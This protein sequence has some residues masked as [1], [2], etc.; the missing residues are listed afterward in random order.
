MTSAPAAG[1]SRWSDRP[2]V[3]SVRLFAGLVLYGT[4]LAVLVKAHLGLDPWTVFSQGLAS[5]T[6]LT[7]GELT[8]IIS[9]VVLLLWIPLRQRPGLGTVANALVVGPVLDLGL[10]VLPDAGPVAARVVYLAVAMAAVAVATGLYVGVGW[11]P[12]PRDGLMTG[13][14]DLGLPIYLA[15]TLIEGTVLVAG[16]LLGGT[17]GVATVVFALSMGPLVARALPRLALPPTLPPAA[18]ASP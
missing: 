14:V 10:A 8:V 3:R 5:R 18:P 6:G 7:L 17:V 15:R 11:G 4:G 1:R 13:L 16:W 12:G 9:L 2:V